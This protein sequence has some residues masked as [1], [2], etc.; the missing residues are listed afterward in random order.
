MRKENIKQSKTESIYIGILLGLIIPFLFFIAGWWISA[1]L[2]IYKIV[3]FSEEFIIYASF[4]GFGLGIVLDLIYLP[5]ITKKIYFISL[6]ICFVFYF[7]ISLIIFAFFMGVPFFNLLLGIL[8]G[9]YIGRRSYF[10]DLNKKD[11]D[12]LIKRAG[13][14][15]SIVMA[16]IAFIAGFLALSSPYAS[17]EL[18]SILNLD[19]N[20]MSP[21]LLIIFVVIGILVLVIGQ[22]YL[23]KKSAG[24]FLNLS[25]KY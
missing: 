14:A 15:T 6:N 20:L 18:A 3:D 23:T 8:A 4:I 9:G 13:L 10:L 2:Y 7:Y 17:E 16:V 24:L 25:R 1:L 5:S 11:S 12:R 21:E 22:Y 19:K